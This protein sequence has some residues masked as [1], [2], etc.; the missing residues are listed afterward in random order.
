M[1]REETLPVRQRTD[2]GHCVSKL[3]FEDMAKI[4]LIKGFAVVA[5]K[6]MPPQR[7]WQFWQ[8]NGDALP[9]P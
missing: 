1:A 9:A 3:Q 8:A 2:S 5:G 4:A 7:T 6:A